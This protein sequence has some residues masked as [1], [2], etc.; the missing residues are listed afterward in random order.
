M[1]REAVTRLHPVDT[2]QRECY[3]ALVPSVRNAGCYGALV[4]SVRN[5]GCYGAVIPSVSIAPAVPN[6]T[7]SEQ[8][9]L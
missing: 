9:R 4:P 1:D 7:S 8:N 6:M 2:T 3:S 5:T